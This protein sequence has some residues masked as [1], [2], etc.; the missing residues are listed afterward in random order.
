MSYNSLNTFN[1]FDLT[2]DNIEQLKGF[3]SSIFNR[4][5]VE[6]KDISDYWLSENAGIKLALL[7]R[8][9]AD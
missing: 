3:Y 1:Y 4:E 9:D 7:K 8:R 6:S 5:L 2:S